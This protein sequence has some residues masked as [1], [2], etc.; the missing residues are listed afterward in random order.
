MK[1]ADNLLDDMLLVLGDYDTRFDGIRR[2]FRDMLAMEGVRGGRYSDDLREAT[3]VY[4][5]ITAYAISQDHLSRLDD[6]Q[7]KEV[8]EHAGSDE[9]VPLIEKLWALE[10]DPRSAG[11][12]GTGIT[13]A[14]SVPNGGGAFKRLAEAVNNA[15]DLIAC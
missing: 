12:L 11:L 7:H 2:T 10:V 9:L 3:S 13:I 14:Y 4:M 6:E 15:Y 5:S 8:V 1:I